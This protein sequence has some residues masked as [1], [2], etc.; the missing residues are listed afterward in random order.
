MIPWKI[1]WQKKRLDLKNKRL[2]SADLLDLISFVTKKSQE[3]LLAH[4]EIN[5]N[6]QQQKTLE[7]LLE[8]RLTAWPLAY[9]LGWRY[10]Y[11]LKLKVSPA[12]LIPRP[13][14]ELLVEN[15]LED[16]NLKSVKNLTIID[17]GTGSG[18]I[19]LSLAQELRKN[20]NIKYWATDISHQALKIAKQNARD[21]K[22]KS[23][24]KFIQADLLSKIKRPPQNLIIAANL[25][26]LTPPQLT[27]PSIKY[28]PHQA[29]FGGQ[30]GLD[31][32]RHLFEQITAWSN[33]KNLTLYL[34]INPQQTTKLKKI[35]QS[36]WPMAKIEIKQDLSGKNRLVIVKINKN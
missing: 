24:I 10:F 11:K 36:R 2:K 22:L 29:L 32:Y 27:E 25:P 5:L 12:V 14:T 6:K 18:A 26:Y 35:A 3:T 28:E 33:F 20:L 34:E 17:V 4:P 8:K 9:L 30:D 19:I 16:I 13:E 31:L 23:K 15:I 21:F 1:Y 7:I